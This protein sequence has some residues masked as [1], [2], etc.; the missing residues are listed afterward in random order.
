MFIDS[1]TG[2]FEDAYGTM[3]SEEYRRIKMFL[4]GK[5]ESLYFDYTPSC[6]DSASVQLRVFVKKEKLPVKVV[7]RKNRIYIVKDDGNVK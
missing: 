5:Y 7:K 3:Y 6:V 2:K 4:N 1:G